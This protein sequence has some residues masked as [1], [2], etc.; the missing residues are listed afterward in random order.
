MIKLILQHMWYILFNS[1]KVDDMLQAYEL[2]K[3]LEDL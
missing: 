2:I 3:K 1:Y